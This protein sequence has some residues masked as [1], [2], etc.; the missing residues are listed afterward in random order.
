MTFPAHGNHAWVASFNSKE[1]ANGSGSSMCDAALKRVTVVLGHEDRASS[2]L[3]C[4]SL[5]QLGPTSGL[6][7]LHQRCLGTWLDSGQG[8]E[9]V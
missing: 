1:V 8:R 6:D 3:L 9:A 4:F 2:K 5:I 7:E